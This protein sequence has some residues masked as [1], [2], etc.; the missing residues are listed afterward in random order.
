MHRSSM[1]RPVPD[2]IPERS[3]G[4][5][6]DSHQRRSGCRPGH[7]FGIEVEDMSPK[8][9]ITTALAVLAL[10]ALSG[11]FLVAFVPGLWWIFTTYG[12][13]AFPAFGL[14]LKGLAGYLTG[15]E[16]RARPAP[17]DGKERELLEALRREGELTPVL[18]TMRTSLTV[19]EADRMLKELAKS[20]HLEVWARG[21]GLSYTLWGAES[22]PRNGATVREDA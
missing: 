7:F 22:P 1:L 8:I 10:V 21:G 2:D 16:N 9:Q 15:P 5:V 20:G 3:R 19:A 6:R 13:I 4:H 14:L 11:L 17:A 12:W 18:A